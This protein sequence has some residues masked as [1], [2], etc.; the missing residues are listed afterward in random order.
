MLAFFSHFAPP[1]PPPPS[2]PHIPYLI[3]RTHY[4]GYIVVKPTDTATS[5][6]IRW[7]HCLQNINDKH[8]R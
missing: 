4:N 5:I 2:L 7:W 1:L 6:I 8:Q 3:V